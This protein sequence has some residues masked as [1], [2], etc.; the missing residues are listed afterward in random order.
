MEQYYHTKRGTLQVQCVDESFVRAEFLPVRGD[1]EWWMR[2]IFKERGGLMM[3]FPV[4]HAHASVGPGHAVVAF[5]SYAGVLP[6]I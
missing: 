2:A 1:G 6:A 3:N 5:G 4:R